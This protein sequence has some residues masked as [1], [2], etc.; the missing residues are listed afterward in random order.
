MSAYNIGFAALALH[1]CRRMRASIVAAIVVSGFAGCTAQNGT[2]NDA[3]PTLEITAPQRGTQSDGASVTVTGN[4]HDDGT[5]RVTVNGTDVTPATDGSFTTTVTVPPGIGIIE[6]HAIDNGGHDVR[7]VRAVLA[8]TLAPSDGKVAAPVGAFAGPE[9]LRAIGT[10]MGNTA[11][12][13]DFTA[14]VQPFNPVYNN[15]GCL[16]AKIDITD[17]ALS[18]IDV[19]LTPGAGIL[20]TAVEIDNVV[21]H[22]HASYKVACLGGST[23]ITVRIAKAHI[24]G[25]LAVVIASGKLTSSV[26]ADAVTLDGFVLDVSGVPSAIEG[27]FNSNVRNAVANSLK[28]V[29]HDR[30]PPIA[31]KA[32]GD[33]VAKPY[34]AAVLGHPT[35]VTVAPSKIVIAPTGL[36]VA[37]DTKLVVTGGEGGAFVSMPSAI[38]SSLMQQGHGLGVAIANDVVNELFGGLWAAGAFD[39]HLSIDKV[40]VLASL[41][42]ADAASLDIEVSLPPTVTTESNKLELSIGDLLVHV[43]DAGGSEIQRIAL[44]LRTSLAAAPS[45]SGKILLTV[46]NTP[47]VHAQVLEQSDNALRPLT[48]AQVEGIITGV[49]GVV[50]GTASDALAKLPMPTI[51]TIQLGAPTISGKAG[52]VVADIPLM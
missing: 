3:P 46:S 17:V 23:T 48:D 18:N 14:A 30:V 44:S 31:D 50:G 26:P 21:I 37:V 20:H 22:L 16:G 33:L 36:F 10:A 42:D 4:V 35:K 45:Q 49:W 13:I 7:D 27:L 5:V 43:K 52:Y 38:T 41:L 8:G 47:E 1:S 24:T 28:T 11:Q 6:T 9:A 34:T 29:I 19:A 39:A 2:G 12:A 51:A 25:D 40:G 15:T 32:L